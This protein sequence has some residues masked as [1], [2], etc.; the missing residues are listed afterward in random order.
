[1]EPL[2]NRK[3]TAEILGLSHKT[4]ERW[5][6]VGG[7]P[8]YIL[9]GGAA[10]YRPSDLENWVNSRTVQNSAQRLDLG[11]GMEPPKRRRGRPRKITLG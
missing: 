6:V 11:K 5:A 8:V 2:L 7:G 4:L 9:V 3:Q 10:R 1:M